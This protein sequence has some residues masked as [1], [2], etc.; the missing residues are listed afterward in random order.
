[1]SVL[2]AA[3][4]PDQTD[5]LELIAELDAY[6]HALYPAESNHLL[7]LNSLLRPNVLF[8]VA[9]DGERRAIGCGAIVLY[10]QYGEIKRMYVRPGGRGQ[11]VAKAMLAAL[12]AGA[13]QQGSTALYLE[14]GIH[15]P[16]AIALYERS[17]YRR[18]G[19]FGDYR[20]DPLS[21]FMRK[22]ADA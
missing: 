9:R 1:M 15:Q 8:V 17:G 22:A 5:V 21:I 10:P 6:Q 12:E 20:D 14:T 13:A 7:D 3:E 16:E 4:S 19:P 18:C 11:G 2:I